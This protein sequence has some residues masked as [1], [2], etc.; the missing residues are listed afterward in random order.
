MWRISVVLFFAC[1]ASAATA[2][3]GCTGDLTLDGTVNLNDLMALL[4]VYG[5]NCP[6]P[7][8]PPEVRFS[9]IHYNPGTAQ[10]NDSDWEFV[11]LY[12]LESY[13]VSLSSWTLAG[14]LSGT[15][16]A[17][18]TLA[19]NG[20]AVACVR[21]DTLGPHVP[22]GVPVFQWPSTASLNNS[23]EIIRLLRPDGSE[24]DMVPFED[25][26]GW[27]TAPDGGGP[28]LEWMDVGLDNDFASAWAASFV[29]GGTPGAP[30]SMWGLSD[31][32]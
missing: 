20:F 19:A 6:A 10:G 5:S 24:S 29:L 17:D 30:N 8:A 14:G 21:A 11:E 3:T 31:P 18:F 12:N 13:P 9:E 4:S 23:G 27:M 22:A 28:S 32:E 26:D 2:Q 25:N 15:F 16:P 7:A 1:A